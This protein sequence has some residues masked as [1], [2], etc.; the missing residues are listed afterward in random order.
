MFEEK[1]YEIKK[2]NVKKTKKNKYVNE[3]F[4]LSNKSKEIIVLLLY[5]VEISLFNEMF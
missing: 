3:L 1:I 2:E 4:L 5:L